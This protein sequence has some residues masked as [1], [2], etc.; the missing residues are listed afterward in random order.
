MAARDPNVVFVVA[1]RL[2]DECPLPQ[3]ADIF[4]LGMLPH[5]HMSYFFSALD[6]AIVALSNTRFGYYAFPQKAYE[7]LACRVPVAA[8]NVGALAQ[9]FSDQPDALY[10]PDLPVS[11]AQTV[12][13][14]LAD[15]AILNVDIPTWDDQAE[16][17]CLCLKG[18][19]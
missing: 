7:V 1:G 17:I 19:Q 13:R 2:Y 5:K 3:R 10:D 8:A 9:L 6:I 16:K 11:L 18:S 14:Q 12:I 4:Y 15:R